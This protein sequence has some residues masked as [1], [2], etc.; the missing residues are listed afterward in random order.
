MQ[1]YPVSLRDLTVPFQQPLTR[2]SPVRK[3]R[4]RVRHELDQHR[5]R[6]VEGQHKI[7]QFIDSARRHS[8]A[9]PAL[10][11][12]P[13]EQAIDWFDQLQERVGEQLAPNIVARQSPW[14]GS[15]DKR[16]RGL[17]PPAQPSPQTLTPKSI[18]Q[19][20]QALWHAQVAQTVARYPAF[21]NLTHAKYHAMPSQAA[22]DL[23]KPFNKLTRI[24][25]QWRETRDQLQRQVDRLIGVRPTEDLWETQFPEDDDSIA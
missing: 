22:P 12:Q 8:E 2:L 1:F 5:D 4:E 21:S 18:Q 23:L 24:P 13:L 25:L 17:A 14:C 19:G 3:V 9:Q 6:I 7:D 20:W 11:H 15:V 16:L 10:I